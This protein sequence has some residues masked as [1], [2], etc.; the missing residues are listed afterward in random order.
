MRTHD[1]SRQSRIDDEGFQSKGTPFRARCPRCDD[2]VTMVPGARA[3]GMGLS[4]AQSPLR[5]DESP[6]ALQCG[7]CRAVFEGEDADVIRGMPLAALASMR[8][9]S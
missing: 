5:A 8:A 1:A 7:A 6:H 3:D 2:E 4:L 9:P